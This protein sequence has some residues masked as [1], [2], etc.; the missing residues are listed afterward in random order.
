VLAYQLETLLVMAA[1][2]AA[3]AVPGVFLV[4]RRLAMT[5]DAIGHVLLL[6]IV[7]AY[8]AVR[9]LSSPWLLAGAAASGVATVALVELLQRSKLLKQD[10]ALGLVFP[11]LFSLGV[12]LA[13]MFLRNTHLDGDAVLLGSAELAW[14]DRITF[15][16]LDVP[17]ALVVMSG[18]FLANALA[19]GV[20]FKEL[21]LGTF[22]PAL[23]ATLGFA[24]AVVHYALMTAVSLTTVAAFDAVGP[25]L[26]V[27]FLVV[28]A[29][30]ATL[31][32]NRLGV[33]IP[34]SVG[35]GV[36]AAVGG[37]GLAMLPGVDTNIAGTA[38]SFLG[39][40]FGLAW[41]VAPDRGLIAQAARRWRQRRAFHEAMLA[42]H[43]LQHEGTA[44]EADESR[45]AG[46]HRHFRWGP[47]EIA[48]V[49]RRA[50]HN[51]LVTRAGE[52]LRLTDLGRARARDVLGS[53][54]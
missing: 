26:V 50:E 38:A 40:V 11:A 41:L 44:A 34:L 31:F 5:G 9:D 46:L 47:H 22:D 53:A 14:L 1:V 39:V 7:L 48:A 20:F 43:L 13:T 21:K 8:F 54:A 51:G 32:T 36:A 33:L 25:V 42:I 3:C 12:I 30:T 24:P 35:I 4:L 28:P 37:T 27:A 10:A 6:G 52:L 23:A 16:G 2:A 49:V 29:A 15:G 18:L 19:A 17:R 45:E